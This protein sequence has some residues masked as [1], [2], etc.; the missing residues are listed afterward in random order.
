MHFSGLAAL[1][2]VLVPK[3]KKELQ[4]QISYMTALWKLPVQSGVHYK[5]TA[6]HADAYHV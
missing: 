6:Q 5:W 3:R 4:K 2:L 1:R